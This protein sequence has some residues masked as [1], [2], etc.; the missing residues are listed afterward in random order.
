MRQAHD[1]NVVAF[2]CEFPLLKITCSHS[3]IDRIVCRRKM[4]RAI[5]FEQKSG[6]AYLEIKVI[7]QVALGTQSWERLLFANVQSQTPKRD[8]TLLLTDRALP[9]VWTIRGL[10]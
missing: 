10:I 5:E 2:H 9:T 8:E 4:L 1:L 6:R 7:T 3:W